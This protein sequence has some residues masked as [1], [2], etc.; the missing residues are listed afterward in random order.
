[1]AV[2]VVLGAAVLF[3]VGAQ[4]AFNSGRIVAVVVPLFALI[5]AALVSAGVA[6][7]RILR[8]R[9]AGRSEASLEEATR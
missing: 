4:V 5:L 2:A 6:G 8:S 1:M 7:G 9:R 3:L